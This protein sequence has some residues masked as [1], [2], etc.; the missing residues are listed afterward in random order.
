VAAFRKIGSRI[1]RRAASLLFRGIRAVAVLAFRAFKGYP[2][3]SLAAAASLLI[4][5]GIWLTQPHTGRGKTSVVT[6]EIT[7]HPFKPDAKDQKSAAG[8]PSESAAADPVTTASAGSDKAAQPILPAPAKSAGNE[9]RPGSVTDLAAAAQKQPKAT[10][11]MA[12]VFELASAPKADHPPAPAPV[13]DQARATLLAETSP[14]M[15]LE[16]P[17]PAPRNDGGGATPS[18]AGRPDA[19]PAP[20][21][22]TTTK[23]QPNEPAPVSA[24][25]AG[26]PQLAIATGPH[27]NQLPPAEK[28]ALDPVAPSASPDSKRLD[29]E[30]PK[31][32]GKPDTERTNDAGANRKDNAAAGPTESTPKPVA[33]EK[34][35]KKP[36]T[37]KPETAL[38]PATAPEPLA[39]LGGDEP[40]A[41]PKEERPSPGASATNQ[42][43]SASPALP[44]DDSKP[45]PEPVA[46]GAQGPAAKPE[47]P[48][49]PP[50][51][52]PDLGSPT[53]DSEK[54]PNHVAENQPRK[55]DSNADGIH[56]EPSRRRDAATGGWI[57]IPNTGKPPFEAGDSI[58]ARSGEQGSQPDAGT[59][60]QRDLRAHAARSVTF[61]QESSLPSAGQS[62]SG[63]SGRTR[64]RFAGSPRPEQE[65]RGRPEYGRVEA[66][67]HLVER[68]ENFWTISRL[69][70]DSGRYYRALWKANSDKYPDINV[71]HVGDTIMIPPVEDLDPAYIVARRS[72]STLS[73]AGARPSPDNRGNDVRPD[74]SDDGS[75]SSG[76]PSARRSSTAARR[77]IRAG[78]EL[79]LPLSDGA[80]QRGRVRDRGG[81]RG[82]LA[83]RDDDGFSDEPETRTAARPRSSGIDS[84]RRP[85]YKVRPYDTLR[86]IARDTLD[87]PRRA[88][89]ILE[90]N[91][92]LIKDP[93]HLVVGQL[94]ELPEDARTTLRRSASRN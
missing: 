67:P 25:L 29:G 93:T 14:G 88:T 37:P 49:Q 77:T 68:G 7:G 76:S 62:A 4:L 71:L 40:S 66:V 87:D 79:D 50:A 47:P 6:N 55:P 8:R 69:Y 92:G 32:A 13:P 70:Y 85:V 78:S 20:A 26:P 34:G 57:S 11:K 53:T 58:E 33:T 61:E 94:L 21:A 63:G 2:R 84:P 65:L 60:M 43:V 19:P 36:E 18:Q 46:P 27:G 28:P 64:Q 23:R 44:T 72:P 24:P 15:D 41:S 52:R 83:A 80:F 91:D 22:T 10:E 16:P 82:D 17:L 59:S 42:V 89:E 12:A 51:D 38:P 90:L 3:A 9:S 75:R 56:D 31:G 30:S 5:G 35:E 54:R 48:A 81:R 74:D 1:L 73:S 39:P 86:S 45:R